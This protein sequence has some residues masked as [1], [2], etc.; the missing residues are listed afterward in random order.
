LYWF[1]KQ[2]VLISLIYTSLETKNTFKTQGVGARM[3]PVVVV[4]LFK[5]LTMP[6]SFFE[7][8]AGLIGAA[9]VYLFFFVLLSF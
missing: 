1:K 9:L 8:F 7:Y 5:G 4:V 3:H 2:E 6:E